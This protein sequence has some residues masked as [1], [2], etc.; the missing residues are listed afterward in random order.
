MFGWLRR[1]DKYYSISPT[2]K[3]IWGKF[4][5]IRREQ[6]REKSIFSLEENVVPI[7]RE[8]FLRESELFVFS[9]AEYRLNW[10]ITVKIISLETSSMCNFIYFSIL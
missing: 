4:K 5:Q 6:L 8:F 3:I 9:H 2:A 7:R 1:A 10:L